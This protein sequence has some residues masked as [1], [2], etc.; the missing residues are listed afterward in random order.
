MLYAIE[1]CQRNRWRCNVRWQIGL[2]HVILKRLPK[3]LEREFDS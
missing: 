3:S 1:N 2:N